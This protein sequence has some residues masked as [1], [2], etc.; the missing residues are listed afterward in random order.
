MPNEGVGYA[1]SSHFLEHLD[2]F[3]ECED[4][5]TECRRVLR[6]GPV[7][8]IAVPDFDKIARFYLDDPKSFYAECDFEK[9]WFS[10]VKTW[11][12]RLGISVMFDHK[13]IYDLVSLEEVLGKAGFVD[14]VEV[15]TDLV[16]HFPSNIAAEIVPTHLSHTLIVD[17]RTPSRP[18]VAKTLSSAFLT[19]FA[20]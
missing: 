7:L 9:P 12:R 2:P 8:R 11:N 1:Y 17:V 20:D 16:G 6:R 14:S 13:M 4:F 19:A 10:R 18:R 3:N 15:G 5:L